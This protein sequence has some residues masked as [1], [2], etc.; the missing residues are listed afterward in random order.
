MLFVGFVRRYGSKSNKK[1]FGA[2][3]KKAYGQPRYETH[4]HLLDKGEVNPLVSKEEF[5]IRRGMLI[6]DFLKTLPLGRRYENHMVCRQV[7][8][9]TFPM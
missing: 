6:H 5:Q 7:R 1:R 9:I 3:Y 8:I 2:N 4:P